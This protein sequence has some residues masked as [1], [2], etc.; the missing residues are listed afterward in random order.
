MPGG[1]S[2]SIIMDTRIPTKYALAVQFGILSEERVKKM[3]VAEIDND[4]GYDRS[5]NKPAV[6][7]TD[8][9]RMGTMDRDSFCE[10]CGCDYNDCPGHFGCITLCKPVYHPGYM[11]YIHKVLRCICFNCSRL[12]LRDVEII[13]KI[14]RL[15][16][17]HLRWKYIYLYCQKIKECR[18][19]DAC[20]DFPE[21]IGCTQA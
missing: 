15:R 14:R 20:V 4:Q 13:N 12:K 19:V 1:G 18:Q 10:T 2:G 3:S 6:G 16:S 21:G 9:P 5:T 7:G 11:T 17:P 8:D